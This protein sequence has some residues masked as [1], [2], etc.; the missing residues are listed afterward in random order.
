MADMLLSQGGL[1]AI[2]GNV[3]SSLRAYQSAYRIF[4]ILKETRS[5]AVALVYI[6]AL[7][8][9]GRDY[10][11]A[12]RYTAQA[13]EVHSGDPDLL[14]AIRNNRGVIFNDTGRYREAETEFN[15]ALALAERLDR[16]LLQSQM[17]RNLARTRL[18]VGDV[19]SAERAIARALSLAQGSEGATWRAQLLAV[20]ATAALQRG[21]PERA[22]RLI[23]DSLSG[24]D[25]TKTTLPYREAHDTA[26]RV[27]R[28]LGR[29]EQALVHLAAFK[30]LDDESTKLA[31]TASTALMGARFD[32][33][34]QELRIAKLRADELRREA[35]VQQARAKSDRNI[36]IVTSTA[37]A[38]VILLLA[39]ALFT[40][41]RSR[42]KV[43]GANDDLAITNAA[44]GKALAAKTE[45]LATTSHEIRTP[46]NGI[47][48]MTQVMLADSALPA[49]T[50]DRLSVVHG[51]GTTMRA[52][53][54]DILDVAKMETGKLVIDATP[55]DLAAMLREAAVMWDEQARGRGL[56]FTLRLDGA[57]RMMLGDAARVRQ[58]VF[59]LLSNALK[60]TERGGVELVADTSADRNEVIISI[61][62]TGIGVPADQQAAIFESF[63]QADTSTTRRFGGTG[64][65]LA[66]CR[67]LA[68]MMGGGIAM[69][70]RPGQGAAFTVTLPLVEVEA[71]T[72]CVEIG[73]TATLLVVEANPITRG[74]WR[75]LLTPHVGA[76][77]FARSTAEVAVALERDGIR[78]VLINYDGAGEVEMAIRAARAAGAS[79][80]LL[81]P[82][83]RQAE[84]ASLLVVGADRVL[85]KPIKGGQLI[86]AMFGS[87][88]DTAL[89]SRAA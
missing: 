53:V 14:N 31:T 27:F 13:A 87:L 47:L 62:D 45:F 24:I 7:Y 40:I 71:P 78:H 72:E 50:R 49:A 52:L 15:E 32:F 65:G 46:L 6:A 29:W 77:A 36:F 51:A 73:D 18:Q 8:S 28:K 30:R 44:L 81:L 22:A 37:T 23:A 83:A 5:Q 10:D 3:A 59:N 35:T 68:E 12:L 74:M 64:L 20:S 21:A 88:A 57:P 9:D 11:T 41:R 1:D 86:E 39:A 75:S 80:T 69:E 67:N 48:G 79:V 58:I 17:W 34:N 33:A 2:R 43:R 63:R 25:P 89:V 54:D 70:S 85:L 16:P 76:P 26:Y 84:R 38:W 4:E 60:F 61:R 56:D 82:T 66:I 42:D 19:E 55:F